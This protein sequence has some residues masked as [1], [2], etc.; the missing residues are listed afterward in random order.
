MIISQLIGGLGN[1]LFQYAAGR[2]L[3]YAQGVEL[4]LDISN[5]SNSTY[6][7][8]RHYELAPFRIKQSFA[9]AKELEKFR[10]PQSMMSRM[11]NRVA[12]RKMQSPV[13]YIR[14]AHFHFDPLI[15][16]LPD[17][18]YLDGYWQSDQ[19]FSDIT[20][21]IRNEAVVTEPLAGRNAEIAQIING[22]EAVSLHIRRGDYIADPVVN[23]V[24]GT[25]GLDYYA[26][27]VEYVA[28]RVSRP[29]FFLFSD[30]PAWVHK[31]LSLAHP[32]YIVDH[33]DIAHG[34]EDM[35]LMSLCRHHII[36]NSS[37][38]WW[39]AWLNPKKDKIVIAPSRWFNCDIQSSD[40][41]PGSWVRI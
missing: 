22:C 25:C 6:R 28:G 3:A 18:V 32:L 39:G 33:N 14:E 16:E 41:I 11:L 7:T 24:H 29:V 23:Q 31:N 17:G 27:A 13:S 30:D 8:I 37:F 2:R 35:R 9:T 4:K 20:E 40:I 34:Y 38:S 36:A 10:P 5:L 1:Q 21:T 26:R 12:R 19:Y 15:L